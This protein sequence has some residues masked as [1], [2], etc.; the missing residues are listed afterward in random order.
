MLTIIMKILQIPGNSSLSRSMLLHARYT[1]I[2]CPVPLRIAPQFK[3][4]AKQLPYH[5]ATQQ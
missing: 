3:D 2:F 5:R 1:A 4:P